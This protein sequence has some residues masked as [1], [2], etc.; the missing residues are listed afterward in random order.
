MDT[1]DNKPEDKGSKPALTTSSS[2]DKPLLDEKTVEKA[3]DIDT[4]HLTLD[5]SAAKNG[6]S[7]EKENRLSMKLFTIKL[8]KAFL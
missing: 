3:V 5:D 6:T 8:K 7:L 1:K 4:S 2:L